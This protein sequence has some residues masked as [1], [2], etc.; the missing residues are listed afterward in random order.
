MQTEISVAR[1]VERS[2][3]AGRPDP[4][5]QL[6][7]RQR[8]Q[9]FDLHYLFGYWSR[10]QPIPDGCLDVEHRSAPI[11]EEAQKTIFHVSPMLPDGGS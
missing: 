7:L 4:I 8:N 9:F 11:A 1:G 5:I 3:L 2:M 10:C 6:R